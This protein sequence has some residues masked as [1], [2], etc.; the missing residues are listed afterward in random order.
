[1]EV[2]SAVFADMI[3]TAQSDGV[4]K[5]HLT[6]T[7]KELELVLPFCLSGKTELPKLLAN[8]FWLMAS[9]LD[10]YSVSCRLRIVESV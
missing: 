3:G 4:D 5:V 7:S 10:K 6:E 1:M 2:N 9:L 8:E